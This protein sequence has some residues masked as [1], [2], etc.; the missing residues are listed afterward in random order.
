MT[1]PLKPFVERLLLRS[2]LS[3]EEQDALLSIEAPTVT[4]RARW[5]LVRP[6]QKVNYSCLVLEGM[7]AR[8]EGFAHGG[9]HTTA[10]FLP[11][12]MCDLHSVPVPIAGWAITA[13]TDVRIAHVPHREIEAVARRYPSVAM[14]LWR[15]TVV[16]GSILSK[17]VSV[18]GSQPAPQR[19][20][21]LLCELGCRV[22]G[23]KLGSRTRFAL[24]LTQEQLAEILGITAVHVNRVFKRLRAERLINDDPREVEILDLDRLL[25]LADFDESYLLLPR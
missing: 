22:E 21:H 18:L 1:Q 25:R 13:L 11:G 10:L 6:G 8:A 3:R 17:W 4:E 9:R 2:E 14:A 19:L 23:A 16:D 20:A 24:P 12:D 15:D 7:A 5:D